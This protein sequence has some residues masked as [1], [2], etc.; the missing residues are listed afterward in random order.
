LRPFRFASILI[1]SALLLGGVNA[2]GESLNEG[3]EKHNPT[4]TVQ[5][6][7]STQE[8]RQQVPFSAPESNQAALLEALH[9]IRA[10]IETQNEQARAE[11]ET[12]IWLRWLTPLRVQ[13]GLLLV[14][15]AYTIF[16]ALQW[17]AIGRQ[18]DITEKTLAANIRP[19]LSI[20]F[21]HP[22][23]ISV[24]NGG[25]RLKL[26][27]TVKNTG[28]SPAFVLHRT[29]TFLFHDQLTLPESPPYEPQGATAFASIEGG[30]EVQADQTSRII[31]DEE[32]SKMRQGLLVIFA[33]PRIV[34]NDEF[35]DT[36]IS[37]TCGAYLAEQKRFI[38]PLNVPSAY[39]KAT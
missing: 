10:Q 4:A 17:C 9:S 20:Q 22:A 1:A 12:W 38:Y 26:D 21:L 25:H 37:A 39:Y 31:T 34:Y 23:E 7:S 27:Y 11:N 28:R 29:L 19:R 15:V 3:T 33:L 32:L 13:Q 18:A 36:H 6:G 2:G 16:A 5:P 35:G 30:R 8:V 24:I 14:G